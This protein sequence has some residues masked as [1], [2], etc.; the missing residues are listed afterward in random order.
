MQIEPL[1]NDV[2]GLSLQ[3]CFSIGLVMADDVFL[4]DS[5]AEW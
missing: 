4:D 3:W 5:L 2:R 1:G